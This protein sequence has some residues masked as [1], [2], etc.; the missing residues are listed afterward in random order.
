M[1]VRAEVYNKHYKHKNYSKILCFHSSCLLL[2]DMINLKST[3]SV[4]I[5]I[6]MN[7]KA[8]Y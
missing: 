3:K 5:V 1:S 4:N 6:K 8:H 7:Y 2:F